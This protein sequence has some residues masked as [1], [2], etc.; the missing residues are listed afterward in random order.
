MPR[1]GA[2]RATIGPDD[3]D[4]DRLAACGL[5]VPAFSLTLRAAA[6]LAEIAGA[7]GQRGQDRIAHAITATRAGM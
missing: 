6:E 5:G 3:L 2:A 4:R 1:L 7:I